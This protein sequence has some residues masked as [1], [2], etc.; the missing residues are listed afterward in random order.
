MLIA[1]IYAYNIKKTT[2]IFIMILTFF[3]YD[4]FLL[5]SN[6]LFVIE[7]LKCNKNQNYRLLLFNEK[8][9]I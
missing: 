1:V 4:S 7:Y 8:H 2:T 5:I 6:D 3:Y 9:L